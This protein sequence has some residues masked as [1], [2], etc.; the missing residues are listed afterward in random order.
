MKQLQSLQNRFAK[1]IIKSKISSANALA[2]LRWV[3][4]HARRFGH[5]CCLVEDAMKGTIPEHF[6]VLFRST[7]NQQHGYNTRNGYMPKVSRPRTEWGK[8]KTYYK[9]INNWATSALKKLMPKTNCNSC[10]YAIFKFSH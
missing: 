8:R 5:R 4:L 10:Y 1:K 9:S 3:S 7:M 2:L 6:S